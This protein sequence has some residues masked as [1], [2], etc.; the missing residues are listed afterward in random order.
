MGLVM[1][2]LHAVAVPRCSDCRAVLPM[3]NDECRR[4]RDHWLLRIRFEDRE[5]RTLLGALN[6]YVLRW[7][8]WSLAWIQDDSTGER[9]GFKLLSDRAAGVS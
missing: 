9:L 5:Y 4:G 8:P 7:T 6:H 2:A 3:H 1:G